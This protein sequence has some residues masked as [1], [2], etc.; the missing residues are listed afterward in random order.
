MVGNGRCYP[1]RVDQSGAVKVGGHP[2]YI[3]R[4]LHRHTIALRVYA[5]QKRLVV[6][7]DSQVFK[8]VPLKGLYNEV[9]LFED[10]LPLIQAEAVSDYRRYLQRQ[11]RYH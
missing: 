4:Q 1:R 2:Y 7:Q 9:M 8:H 6:L 11:R 10:H 3:S 5:T